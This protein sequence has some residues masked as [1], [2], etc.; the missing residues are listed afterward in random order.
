LHKQRMKARPGE[1]QCKVI[2]KSQNL[3]LNLNKNHH[4]T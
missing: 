4:P 2:R 3:F 1:G